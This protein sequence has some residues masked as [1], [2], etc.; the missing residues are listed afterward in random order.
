MA[1]RKTAKLRHGARTPDQEYGRDIEMRETVKAAEKEALRAWHNSRP[2]GMNWQQL[3]IAEFELE[4]AA[5]ANARADL[6]ARWAKEDAEFA[7]PLKPNLTRMT[8]AD[9]REINN[10]TLDAKRRAYVAEVRKLGKGAR[11]NES[12]RLKHALE[13]GEREV[14]QRDANERASKRT[15]PIKSYDLIDNGRVIGDHHG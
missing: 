1:T 15:T 14:K 4:S 13:Q 12:K 3:R 2:P 9:F 7:K 8:T 5:R 10:E 11:H 6:R